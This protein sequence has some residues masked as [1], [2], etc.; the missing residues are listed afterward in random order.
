MATV[1]YANEAAAVTDGWVFATRGTDRVASRYTG[2]T[3]FEMRADSS[4]NVLTKLGSRATY[5]SN[6]FGK[7]SSNEL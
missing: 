2:S 1:T 3:R 5:R 6:N 4:A 7:S